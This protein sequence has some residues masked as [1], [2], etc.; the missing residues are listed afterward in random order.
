MFEAD[1]ET[2]AEIA[3]RT[4]IV[5]FVLLAFLRLAGKRQIGQMAPFDLLVII[6]IA[7]AVGVSMLG[8]DA[9]LLGGLVAAGV[10]VSVNYVVGTAQDR[11][12]WL[13]RFLEGEPTVLV[14]DGKIDKKQAQQENISEDEIMMAARQHGVDELEG[15]ELAV[16]ETDGTISVVSKDGNQKTQP[17]KRG[18]RRR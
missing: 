5:Y 3:L 4:V 16:L 9:T 15:V 17:R 8:D 11:I 14:R 2:L 1:I 6:L 18:L 7:E 13:R 10:L 12:P